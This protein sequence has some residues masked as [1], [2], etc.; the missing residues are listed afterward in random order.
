MTVDERI[1]ALTLNLELAFPDSQGLKDLAHRHG[2]NIRALARMAEAHPRRIEH[3][4]GH[5]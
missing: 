4:E 5:Q 3:I 1:E 2:E